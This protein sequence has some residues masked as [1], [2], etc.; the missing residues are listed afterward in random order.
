M[1][2]ASSW[3]AFLWLMAAAQSCTGSSMTYTFPTTDY[4]AHES[5]GTYNGGM[6][7]GL[8]VLGA[9]EASA[10]ISPDDSGFTYT[11]IPDLKDGVQAFGNGFELVGI[12]GHGAQ[13]CEG[14]IYLQPSFKYGPPPGVDVT[15]EATSDE[16]SAGVTICAFIEKKFGNFDRQGNWKQPLLEQGFTPSDVKFTFAKPYPDRFTSYC[17]LMS[18]KAVMT[19]RL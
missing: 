16:S 18:L 1:Y 19:L 7:H 6:I 14:G 2:F 4:P 10:T 3:T 12:D 5:T 9:T 17:K 13:V 15:V 8:C 11:S